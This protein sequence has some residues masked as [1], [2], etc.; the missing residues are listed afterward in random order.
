MC[1][2]ALGI[3]GG[4]VLLAVS[5]DYA[6]SK[7]RLPAGTADHRARVRRWERSTT[8]SYGKYRFFDHE[9]GGVNEWD[10][11]P[12]RYAI[13]CIQQ[14]ST[15]NCRN[16]YLRGHSNYCEIDAVAAQGDGHRV[17]P[18]SDAAVGAIHARSDHGLDPP[19]EM[20]TL[21]R[22]ARTRRLQKCGATRVN[23]VAED[24][25]IHSRD[26]SFDLIYTQMPRPHAAAG[27]GVENV[28]RH[29]ARMV[30]RFKW[31]LVKGRARTGPT[32]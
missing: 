28:S 26:R 25:E 21:S 23:G 13:N 17:R 15:R 7:K 19:I 10:G 31:R 18:V 9:F 27:A 14:M 8:I 30:L 4:D 32:S 20:Y 29:L 6:I 24:M 2:A 1:C 16:Y 11:A 12:T 22:A 3:G 5:K